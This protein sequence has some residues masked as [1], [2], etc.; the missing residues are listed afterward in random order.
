VKN[1]PRISLG[2]MVGLMVAL[3][4]GVA[5]A[6]LTVAV[7]VSG[8]QTTSPG[9]NV[10]AGQFTVT[11]TSTTINQTVT[12][13]QFSISNP[14]LFSSMTLTATG[15]DSVVQ[16]ISVPLQNPSTVTFATAV[17]VNLNQPAATFSL[18]A[19][20]AGGGATATPVSDSGSIAFASVVWPHSQAASRTFLTLLG[21]F[22]VGML[23]MD[24]RLKR[25][26]L[27]ALVLAL[28]LAAIEAGC[29]NCSNSLFGCGGGSNTGT[30]SSDQ[31]VTEIGTPTTVSLTGVPADLGTITSQN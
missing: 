6:Q 10:N 31:Q 21:L 13:V 25:R 17:A 18:N 19:T 27:V 4:A 20:I 1:G 12:S 7:T 9:S 16:S 11:N 28:V 3:C 22:A 15:S 5:Q 8:T 30:G 23:W 2:L 26:H 29:G 24:G 14:N